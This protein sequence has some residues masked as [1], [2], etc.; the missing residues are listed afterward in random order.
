MNRIKKL[1][2]IFFLIFIIILSVFLYYKTLCLEHSSNY[3]LE[4]IIDGYG[5]VYAYNIEYN[6]LIE[7][8]KIKKS[9]YTKD[10]LKEFKSN[11][12]FSGMKINFK[13]LILVKNDVVF[14]ELNDISNTF[15]M[16]FDSKCKIYK[17][18]YTSASG[19]MKKLNKD[20]RKVLGY[21]IVISSSLQKNELSI[22]FT[23]N[24]K[25]IIKNGLIISEDNL[26]ISPFIINNNN[27]ALIYVP[28]CDILDMFNYSFE[29]NE[30]GDIIIQ[31]NSRKHITWKEILVNILADLQ[32]EDSFISFSLCDFTND[33]IPELLIELDDG[34]SYDYPY[35]KIMYPKEEL[36]FFHI[37]EIAEYPYHFMSEPYICYYFNEQTKIWEDKLERC[38]GYDNKSEIVLVQ[39]T[40]QDYD[41]IHYK[42]DKEK[43]CFIDI[44]TIIEN[45]IV[46][47]DDK[48]VE[49]IKNAKKFKTFSLQDIRNK[50]ININQMINEYPKSFDMLNSE[51]LFLSTF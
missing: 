35:P 27:I 12:E 26:S 25:S 20:A 51:Y 38:V 14:I 44:S 40:A 4:E 21:D 34:Y 29:V 28:L 43:K 1:Y 39:Q 2:Y 42:W 36:G 48:K 8:D 13:N 15:Q 24:S 41:T 7:C 46:D 5:N 17:N 45:E 23:P 33:N 19:T 47:I 9:F 49:I 50:K 32:K 6:K 30:N 3:D 31:D 18:V 22:E 11:I 16:E 37:Y 10:K